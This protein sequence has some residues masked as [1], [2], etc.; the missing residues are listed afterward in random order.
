MEEEGKV[1]TAR[2]VLFGAVAV[3]VLAVMAGLWFLSSNIADTANQN[4]EDKEVSEAR[5]SAEAAESEAAKAAETDSD[6]SDQQ[7][8]VDV[9]E[10]PGSDEEDTDVPNVKAPVDQDKREV[11]VP[12]ADFG[13]KTKDP[14]QGGMADERTLANTGDLE[15]YIGVKSTMQTDYSNCYGTSKG[16]TVCDLKNGYVMVVENYNQTVFAIGK[17]D[18][19]LSSDQV[20]MFKET[21]E[22]AE[23]VEGSG[24]LDGVSL[25]VKSDP[26]DISN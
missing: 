19:D 13:S 26:T 4:R 3:I 9:T 25:V 22:S 17:K 2:K 15:S 11:T 24:P 20:S 18:G 6:F 1:K 12:T 8:G 10:N 7:P 16:Y 21:F 23:K 14:K 5:K